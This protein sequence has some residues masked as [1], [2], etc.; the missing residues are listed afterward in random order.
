MELSGLSRARRARLVK[1]HCIQRA[2]RMAKNR[3]IITTT[4]DA[5]T[6]VARTGI[7]G[8]R[9]IAGSAADTA[10]GAA[11]SAAKVVTG[12]ALTAVRGARRFVG[13]AKKRKTVKRRA[14][15]KKAAK[16]KAV[17]KRRP[18]KKSARKTV[19]RKKK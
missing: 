7:E 16:R 5:I 14:K 1:I 15:V 11:N 3:G 4:Q 13:P 19:R 12:A 10:A 9:S 18:A 17:A 8:A 2:D 6:D